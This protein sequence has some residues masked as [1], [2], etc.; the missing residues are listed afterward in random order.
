MELQ[1][2]NS[3]LCIHRRTICLTAANVDDRGEF[4]L[5]QFAHEQQREATLVF[6]H[7]LLVPCLIVVFLEHL[8]LGKVWV[9]F[10]VMV[11]HGEFERARV[12]GVCVCLSEHT[13]SELPEK[14][15]DVFLHL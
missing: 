9:D 6:F 3:I 7:H 13:Q 8:G 10:L 2:C 1:Q 5:W 12:V 4:V 11:K 14:H 15:G